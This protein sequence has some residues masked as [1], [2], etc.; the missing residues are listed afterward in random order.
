[1]I[2]TTDSNRKSNIMTMCG[3]GSIII[4][5]DG[6]DASLC[7]AWSWFFFHFTILGFVIIASIGILLNFEFIVSVRLSVDRSHFYW[8]VEF[9]E[10]S[11]TKR[12]FFLLHYCCVYAQCTPLN[13]RNSA[14]SGEWI[15]MYAWSA[16]SITSLIT[17]S[18]DE[19]LV[20]ERS[21]DRWCTYNRNA[22]IQALKA[23]MTHF[24]SIVWRR[25]WND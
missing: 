16:S 18:N 6:N 7:Y 13:R 12:F 17:K 8:C 3:Y 14:L 22:F 25:Q 20:T 21:I 2:S 19:Q 15:W 9:S 11:T 5:D 1:M 23:S 10:H 24:I 4:G